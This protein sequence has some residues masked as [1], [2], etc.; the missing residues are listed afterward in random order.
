[1]NPTDVVSAAAAGQKLIETGDV[2]ACVVVLQ[3]GVIVWLIKRLLD[4]LDRNSKAF[5]RL[6]NMLDDRP[7]LHGGSAFK[8]TSVNRNED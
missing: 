7:C 8:T 6:S 2:L 1:M 3:I 4:A 5:E